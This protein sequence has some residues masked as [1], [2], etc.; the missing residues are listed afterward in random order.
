MNKVIPKLIL[1]FENGNEEQKAFHFKIRDNF[2]Y[3]K[4]VGYEIL[5]S[6]INSNYSIKVKIGKNIYV[7]SNE[8]KNSEEH[9]HKI[10]N[11]I[12]KLLDEK[13]K[14]I[15]VLFNIENE[16]QRKYYQK[17][18]NNNKLNVCYK[19][20][21]EPTFPFFIKLDIGDNIYDIQTEF[22][23]SEEA[24][25]KALNKIYELIEEYNN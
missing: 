24:M 25:N 12:Y 2:Q 22:D 15:T 16:E 20:T 11:D 8:F 7:I 19:E 10:L 21:K 14:E 23:D 3:E 18:K 1:E 6:D 4:S 5:S 13:Y 17:L 9:L